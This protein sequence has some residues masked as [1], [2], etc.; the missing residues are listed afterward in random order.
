MPCRPTLRVCCPL[1]PTLALR[2]CE[3]GFHLYC[4]CPQVPT[5]PAGDWLCRACD[6]KAMQ[7][8]QRFPLKQ[9][10]LDRFFKIERSRCRAMDTEGNILKG[11]HATATPRKRRPPLRGG[12]EGERGEQQGEQQGTQGDDSGSAGAQGQPATPSAPRKPK[13]RRKAG[14]GTALSLP[15]KKGG[16]AIKAFTPVRDPMRR[17]ELQASL[18]TAIR[19]EGAEY[20]EELVYVGREQEEANRANLEGMQRLDAASCRALALHKAQLAAGDWPALHVRHDAVEGFVVEAYA[21]IQAMTLICEYT[22]EVD[23][24]R[25]YEK[26]H[27]DCLMDLLVLPRSEGRSLTISAQ[28]TCNIARFISGVN[29]TVPELRAK[30]N[31]KAVRF[32]VGGQARVLL[33]ALRRIAEGERLYYNYNE[34]RKDYEYV[35]APISPRAAR[36]LTGL[37]SVR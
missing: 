15:K 24:A 12:A 13:R 2:R 10:Q 14:T 8:I 33:V 21:P 4:L 9:L 16:G 7:Q 20:S 6:N 11:I 30:Q 37:Q 23:W 28:H 22:G 31:V 1:Y 26:D 25:R 3:K 27:A 17:L 19:H 32:E 5:I 18:A 36:M 34:E 35:P 29:D